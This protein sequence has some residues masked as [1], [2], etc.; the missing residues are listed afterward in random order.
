MEQNLPLDELSVVI[1]RIRG[2]LLTEE[3]VD[4][5]VH[6]LARAIKE[7]IPGTVGAGVSLMDS[8]GHRTSAGFTDRIVERVDA[9]QYELGQGPCL[10]AWAAE[11]TVLVEDVRADP[12]WPDWSAAVEALPVRSVVSSALVSG[13]E[14]IGALKVYAALPFVYDSGTGQLLE[15]FAAPAATLLSHIQASE[16]PHRMSAGLQAALHSRDAVNRACG[17]LMERHGL[18]YEQALQQLMR[19]A[20]DTAQTLP[21]ISAETIAGT[22]ANRN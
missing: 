9:L 7:A 10:T 5:A 19:Q 13:R 14:C 20:R 12:R 17:I 3:K 11:E 22:P 1:G 8:Q 18:S 4:R 21:Q 2:L 16:V 15:L 6:T